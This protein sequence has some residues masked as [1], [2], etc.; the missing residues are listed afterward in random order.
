MKKVILEICFVVNAL[1]CLMLIPLIITVLFGVDFLYDFL[2]SEQ[3]IKLRLYI[4]IPIIVLW[5]NNVIV[6]SKNDK[7]VGRLI[8]ILLFNALYNPF[9]YRKSVKNGWIIKKN[10]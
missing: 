4:N 9:Y 3:G 7:N 5:I 10:N 6:W 1:F 8:L 2:K